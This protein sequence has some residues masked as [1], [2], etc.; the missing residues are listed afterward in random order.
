[1]GCLIPVDSQDRV[2]GED[3]D[4]DTT[5][6]ERGRTFLFSIAASETDW[7]VVL[8]PPSSPPGVPSSSIELRFGI[9]QTVL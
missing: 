4:K 6:V 7:L 2:C 5:C 8:R 3:L 9:L 1:M